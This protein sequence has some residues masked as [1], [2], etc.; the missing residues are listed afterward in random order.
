MNALLK[1]AALSLLLPTAATASLAQATAP[2]A[3]AAPTAPGDYFSNWPAGSSPQ[4]VGKRLSEHFVTTP[5]QGM[6]SIFYGECAT[7][8]ARAA[9]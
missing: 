9:A 2:A 7:V 6:R 1:I 5:H 4:E 8:P 3:S